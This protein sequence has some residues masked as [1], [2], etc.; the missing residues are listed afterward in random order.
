M[1]RSDICLY[2]G[3]ADRADLQ[4][5][6]SNRSQGL[7][8]GTDALPRIPKMLVAVALA[9]RKL[10]T[11]WALLRNGEDDRDRPMA[12]AEA[13]VLGLSPDVRGSE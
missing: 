11:A 5:L 7:L 3:P 2:L 13:S 6:L 12:A 4:A 8:A 9:N 1:R 10:R